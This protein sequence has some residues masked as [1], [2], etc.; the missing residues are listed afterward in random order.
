MSRPL[1][2]MGSKFDL[3]LSLSSFLTA[4]LQK[5]LVCTSSSSSS[6]SREQQHKEYKTRTIRLTSNQNLHSQKSV[7]KFYA[8]I[9]KVE[10]LAR[11]DDTGAW[12]LGIHVSQRIKEEVEEKAL[13]KVHISVSY[14]VSLLFLVLFICVCA[15]R[16]YIEKSGDRTSALS[17]PLNLPC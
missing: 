4:L 12:G 17:L 10:H 9:S 16:N 7:L 11:D 15:T 2:E 1:A 13:E 5:S 6:G 14:L 8:E 3:S